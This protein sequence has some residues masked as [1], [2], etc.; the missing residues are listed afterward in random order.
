M[1]IQRG[2]GSDVYTKGGGGSDVYTKGKE[3]VM[4]IQRGRRRK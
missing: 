3:E 2:R 1:Y 4:Y